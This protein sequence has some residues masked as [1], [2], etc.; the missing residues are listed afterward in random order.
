MSTIRLERGWCGGKARR[1]RLRIQNPMSSH[2]SQLNDQSKQRPSKHRTS[3]ALHSFT[4]SSHQRTG[5][6]DL[7]GVVYHQHALHQATING[8]TDAIFHVVYHRHQLHQK[9]MTRRYNLLRCSFHGRK[10]D[11]LITVHKACFYG[12]ELLGGTGIESL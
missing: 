10:Y 11:I 6:C 1:I 12:C 3:C 4:S 7:F 9:T 2:V 8:P 5:E